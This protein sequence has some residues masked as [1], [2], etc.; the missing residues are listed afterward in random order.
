MQKAKTRMLMQRTMKLLSL[1]TFLC[2]NLVIHSMEGVGICVRIPQTYTSADIVRQLAPRLFDI[3]FT[4]QSPVDPENSTSHRFH[5][6][7][8]NPLIER[9]EETS[10][11][12]YRTNRRYRYCG[13][14][15]RGFVFAYVV[16][17]SIIR[18]TED[19]AMVYARA[20][21]FKNTLLPAIFPG[22]TIYWE[23][24]PASQAQDWQLPIIAEV[25]TDEFAK[26][27]QVRLADF[28]QL[29]P[30]IQ[31]KLVQEG[32]ERMNPSFSSSLFTMLSLSD[33]VFPLILTFFVSIIVLQLPKRYRV[34]VFTLTFAL[35]LSPI[36]VPLFST[37]ILPL[38]LVI[39]TGIRGGVS[40]IVEVGLAFLIYVHWNAPAV[41]FTA[42]I[43]WV[44]GTPVYSLRRLEASCDHSKC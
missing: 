22:L 38:G 39:W 28:R 43:G 26:N 41:V 34:T 37:S 10:I 15:D 12:I 29:E 9:T 35:N 42:L 5:W 23:T 3:G 36:M 33:Y 30:A 17:N 19:L 21:F 40:G 14:L 1:C 27:D 25:S 8:T 11:E 24:H 6:Y 16:D 20:Y 31:E 7:R 18:S 44:L 2:S 32:L 4:I 13:S